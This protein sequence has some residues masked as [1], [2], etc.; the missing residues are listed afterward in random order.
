[1][2]LLAIAAMPLHECGHWLWGT[3]IDQEGQILQFTKVTRSDGT[4][5]G[6]FGSIL[7]GPLMSAFVAAAGI[8]WMTLARTPASRFIAATLALVVSLQRLTIYLVSIFAGMAGN[9]EGIAARQLGLHDWAIALPIA[10]VFA[11][12]VVVA[13]T[14]VPVRSKP[15]WFGALYVSLVGLTAFEFWLDSLIFS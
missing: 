14:C 10:A 13:W 1:M 9:D 7:A 15:V 12:A 6:T 5:L 4:T 11:I 2:F 3:L 8:A